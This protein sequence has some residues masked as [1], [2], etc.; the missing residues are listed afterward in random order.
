MHTKLFQFSRTMHVCN[1]LAALC[2]SRVA[3]LATSCKNLANGSVL[4]AKYATYCA[5]CMRKGTAVVVRSSFGNP[6]LRWVSPHASCS[7]GSEPFRAGSS[8]PFSML[9][10]QSWLRC[11]AV[12]MD[13]V[14][15]S[16]APLIRH[17]LILHR[18]QL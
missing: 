14:V 2:E 17:H 3:A 6:Y 10:L 5:T 4:V 18:L 12:M 13:G 1:Q 9:G 16:S 8:G 11:R 7:H 15:S